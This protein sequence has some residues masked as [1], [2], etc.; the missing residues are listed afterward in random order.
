MKKVHRS[1]LTSRS[2]ANMRLLTSTIMDILIITGAGRISGVPWPILH[3][4]LP[5]AKLQLSPRKSKRLRETTGG[6]SSAQRGR[7]DRVLHGATDGEIGHLEDFIVDDESWT[8]RYM[9]VDTRN[10]WPGR[11]VLV[12]PKWI[13]RV[14]WSD[15]MV[16][17]DLSRDAIK[18]GPPIR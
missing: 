4:C 6:S 16:Y 2:R 7:S 5:L 12:A 9:V 10:W 3:F 11:K 18:N 17:V 8:I 14:R 1:T 15:S 13:Q